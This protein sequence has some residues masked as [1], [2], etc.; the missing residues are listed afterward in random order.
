MKFLAPI[1]LTLLTTTLYSQTTMCFKENHPSMS[2]IESTKLDGGECK[3][4]YTLS[5]MKE[6]GWNVQDIKISNNSS[7]GYNYIY[8]LKD[9]KEQTLNSALS[10]KQLENKII[11]RLE[12][13]KIK[14]KKENEAKKLAESI[15]LGKDIYTN[16]CQSCHGGKGEKVAYNVGETLRDLSIQDIEHKIGRYTNDPNYGYGYNLIMRPIAAGI[17]SENIENIKAYLDSINK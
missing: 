7:G 9:S 4:T 6:M 1:T 5:E 17:T 12:E 13:K 8:I 10:E 14:E 11:K 15:S 16:K 2:T 3:S